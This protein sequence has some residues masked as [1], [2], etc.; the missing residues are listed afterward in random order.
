MKKLYRSRSNRKICGVCGGLSE[1][2]GLDATVIRLIF[3][4]LACFTGVG[5]LVYQI[6][7][8]V[9]PYKPEAGTTVEGEKVG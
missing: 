1:Y 7:A 6:A 5:I 9:I 3:A 4:L 2:I 8:L